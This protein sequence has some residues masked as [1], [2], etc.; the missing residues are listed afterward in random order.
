MRVAESEFEYIIAYVLFRVLTYEIIWR[1]CEFFAFVT[2]QLKFAP[3]I[4]RRD[5]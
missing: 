4:A 5:V 2:V 1:A 3:H